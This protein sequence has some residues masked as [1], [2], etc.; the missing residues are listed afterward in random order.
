MARGARAARVALALL[1]V[2]AAPR[3]AV[4]ARRL[5]GARDLAQPGVFVAP[6]A[7]VERLLEL[8]KVHFRIKKCLVFQL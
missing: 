7:L 4:L 5:G 2:D 3:P 8:V 1:A 6:L